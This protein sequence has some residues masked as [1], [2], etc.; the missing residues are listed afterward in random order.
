MEK[1]MSED[2][3]KLQIDQALIKQKQD[4][5]DI[6]IEKL[7]DNMASLSKNVVQFEGKV[8]KGFYI[9]C[10]IVLMASG[11]LDTVAK[12]VIKFVGG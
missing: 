1:T 5:T 12:V 4:Q 8:T 10:G 11:S 7:S 2:I 9:A 3:S 6:V